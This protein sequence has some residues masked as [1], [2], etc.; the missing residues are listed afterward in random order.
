MAVRTPVSVSLGSVSVRG[1]SAATRPA[2]SSRSLTVCAA[3]HKVEIKDRQGK[4]HAFE[5]GGTLP[6]GR[7]GALRVDKGL[8]AH[9][10]IPAHLDSLSRCMIIFPCACSWLAVQVPEDALILETA[11]N[12]GIRDIPHQCTMGVCMTCASKLVRTPLPLRR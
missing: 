10:R 3:K 6:S 2:A 12:Q 8:V 4:T 9:I 5:V 11:L 7:A 1:R